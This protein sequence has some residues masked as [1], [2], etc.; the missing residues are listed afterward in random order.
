MTDFLLPQTTPD[1]S[2]YILGLH[3]FPGV[4]KDTVA[5]YLCR[6]YGFIKRA[7]ADPLYVEVSRAFNI[8][9]EALRLRET[10]E[11]P[12]RRLTLKRC[13]DIR[14]VS[15]CR[16]ILRTE[17][18]Q[19]LMINPRSPREILRWWGTDLRR[20]SEPNYWTNKM[21]DYIDRLPNSSR[22]VIPDVRFI[23]EA[24]VVLSYPHL[25][26]TVDCPA[27][28][29]SIIELLRDGCVGSNHQSDVRLANGLLRT[30]I[31]N[32]QSEEA[33]FLKVDA[34]ISKAF[35]N[36]TKKHNEVC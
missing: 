11:L 35:P 31:T 8:S 12:T 16:R 25:A 6:E 32:D 14:F 18:E 15:T 2:P 21:R 19:E 27:T 28:H 4:G 24:K 23:D 20:T 33:L 3:G 34:W 30:T 36:M 7:F 26:D 1:N 22:L 29:R 17:T 13:A 5:D 10:K 9:I